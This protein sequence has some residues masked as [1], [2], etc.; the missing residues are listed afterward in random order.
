[1]NGILGKILFIK[2]VSL[3]LCYMGLLKEKDPA[4]VAKIS[5]AAFA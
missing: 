4:F 3:K 5:K 1:M 2:Y